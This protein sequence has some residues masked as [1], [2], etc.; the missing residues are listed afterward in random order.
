V[1]VER[2]PVDETE[3]D[4]IG[5]GGI[6]YERGCPVGRTEDLVL[7]VEQ[8]RC[9]IVDDNPGFLGAAASL[10]EREGIR[11]VGVASNIAEALERVQELRPDVTL[12]D[13]D[14]SGES[15]F[16]LAEQLHQHGWGAQS[17]VI[18]TSA[19]S[20]RDFADMIAASP[21]LGFLSKL[22]LSSRAIRD[23]MAAGDDPDAGSS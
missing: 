21:A 16:D 22:A 9:V 11:V 15:G 12:V 6:G 10:L 23:L 17:A 1:P 13:V 19:H 2:E 4:E 7:L 18:L 20:E 5:T 8:L 3:Q 14:L